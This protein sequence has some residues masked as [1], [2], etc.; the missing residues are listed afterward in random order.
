[1]VRDCLRRPCLSRPTDDLVRH[2]SHLQSIVEPGAGDSVV[3]PRPAVRVAKVRR[4]LLQEL[5]V[6][7]SAKTVL[8]RSCCAAF[9][10][11]EGNLLGSV[12]NQVVQHLSR[13]GC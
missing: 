1:M 10:D 2:I 8:F 6:G 13:E 11:V 9:P 3:R 12:F 5:R 4:W 7:T